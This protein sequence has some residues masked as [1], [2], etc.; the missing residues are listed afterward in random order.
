MKFKVGD[1][2]RIKDLNGP[3]ITIYDIEGNAITC[4]WFDKNDVLRYFHCN[5]DELQS[6][7]GPAPLPSPPPTGFSW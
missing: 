6:Y 1:K 3:C 2:V 5:V 4:R 7:P